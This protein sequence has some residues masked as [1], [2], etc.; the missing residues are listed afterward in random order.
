MTMGHKS[1]TWLLHLFYN[2]FFA[3]WLY[4]KSFNW[5]SICGWFND[6]ESLNQKHQSA[7]KGT[8][9]SQV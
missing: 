5:W 8:I 7:Q 1:Y 9:P 3:I 4:E 2:T 6:F